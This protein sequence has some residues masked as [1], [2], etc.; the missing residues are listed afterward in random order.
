M[1]I[2]SQLATA[3]LLGPE[4]A[5]DTLPAVSCC[6]TDPVVVSAACAGAGGAASSSVLAIDMGRVGQGV[7]AHGWCARRSERVAHRGACAASIIGHGVAAA[8][9]AGCNTGS[10]RSR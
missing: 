8:G 4:L 7:V 2:L 5:A 3:L 6:C 1:L 9:V 10:G